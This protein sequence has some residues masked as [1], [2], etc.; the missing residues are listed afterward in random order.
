MSNVPIT[1]KFPSVPAIVKNDMKVKYGIEIVLYL[2]TNSYPED[3]PELF[4][5]FLI[6]S[7]SI[8]CFVQ[9]VNV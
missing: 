7:K 1:R 3:N 5:S 4:S 9:A 8:L 2:V 6:I